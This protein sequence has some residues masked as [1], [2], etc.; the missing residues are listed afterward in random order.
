[1]SIILEIRGKP[2]L[3][4]EDVTQILITLFAGMM[5]AQYNS[6]AYMVLKKWMIDLK[7]NRKEVQSHKCGQLFVIF[8]F[9]DSLTM[10]SKETSK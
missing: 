10:L 9:P 6:F 7:H 4:F 8:G 1:M 3:E 2:S 5:H